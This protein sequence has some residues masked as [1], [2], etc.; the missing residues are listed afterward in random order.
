MTQTQLTQ[1]LILCLRV[2][3]SQTVQPISLSVAHDRVGRMESLVRQAIFLL[4]HVLLMTL[5][6][7]LAGEAIFATVL[8]SSD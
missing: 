7:V 8:A 6:L 4:M 3:D 5:Q 1:R 2:A